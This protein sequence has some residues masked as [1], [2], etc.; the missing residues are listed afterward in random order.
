M[1]ITPTITPAAQLDQ[2]IVNQSQQQQVTSAETSRKASVTVQFSPEARE[3]AGTENKESSQQQRQE[4][5][6]RAATK[7]PDT[8]QIS[9]AGRD[10][11]A[12]D[13][14]AIQAQQ[15]TPVQINKQINETIALNQ[16][17]PINPTSKQPENNKLLSV[18]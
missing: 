4:A 16:Q 3:L 2:T 10:L 11:S 12:S 6:Q 7:T 14:T 5:L 15:Q 17:Q 1:I 8:V 9:S 13:N 18:A